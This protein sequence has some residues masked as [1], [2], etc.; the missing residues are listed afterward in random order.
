[1]MSTATGTPSH[2]LRSLRKIGAIRA[3][4]RIVVTISHLRLARGRSWC[5]RGVSRL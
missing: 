5:V 4:T 2:C 3:M 1:M